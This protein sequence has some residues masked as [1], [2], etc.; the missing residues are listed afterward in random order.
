TRRVVRFASILRALRGS[1][2][3]PFRVGDHLLSGTPPC[4]RLAS[5]YSTGPRSGP[6]YVVLVHHHLIDPIRPTRGHT[7]T[8][9][10]RLIWGAFAVRERLGDPRVVP[11][12]CC[13]MPS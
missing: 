1:M 6:G 7:P 11:G 8:S 2:G 3:P 5:L 4:E 13:I 9:P 10:P 12:F